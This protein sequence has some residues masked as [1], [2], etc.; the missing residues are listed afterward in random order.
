MS[1]V[2]GING[3]LYF[4]E[5]GQW[6]PAACY[7]SSSISISVDTVDTSVS[8]TG[9]WTT[10][11][12]TRISASGTIEGLVSL[13]PTSMLSLADLTARMIAQTKMLFRQQAQAQDGTYYTEQGY[14]YL[15][16]RPWTNSFDNVG[17]FSFDFKVT[18]EITQ[19]FT[20]IVQPSPIMYRYEYT[21]T[22]GE[23]TF[24]NAA[25]I[26]KQLIAGGKDMGSFPALV[27]GTS[28]ASNELGYVVATGQLSWAI[29]AEPGEKIWVNYQNL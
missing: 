25:L 22:G 20:P 4:F 9:L 3:L 13:N 27:T 21:A 23:T 19:L 6:Y 1:L 8:G 17:T 16:G 11:A 24:T 7:R 12:P 5:N 28:P 2:N 29:A 10:S 14:C 26:D 15:V 18:G